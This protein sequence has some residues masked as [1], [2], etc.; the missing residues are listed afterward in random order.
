MKLFQHI[1][2]PLDGSA[3]SE[4]AIPV[5]MQLAENLGSKVTLLR[6]LEIPIPSIERPPEVMRQWIDETVQL[7]HQEANEYLGALAKQF[8]ERG[9]SVETIVRD[10]APEEDILSVAKSESVDL[11]VMSPHGR[12]YQNIGGCLSF[13]SIADKVMRRSTCPVLLVRGGEE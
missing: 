10:Q 1:L 11:I 7:A 8:A 5:A 2:A 9:I 6:V 4:R 12:G 13:G 3:K